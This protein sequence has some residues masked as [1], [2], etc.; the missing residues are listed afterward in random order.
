MDAARLFVACRHR[1]APC[2][3]RNEVARSLAVRL[4][5][6]V[7]E[8][9]AD[10]R[11]VADEKRY[12]AVAFK[13]SAKLLKLDRPVLRQTPGNTVIYIKKRI[14]DLISACVHH[15]ADK[16]TGGDA[17]PRHSLKRRHSDAVLFK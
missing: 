14:V 10:L 8:F 1:N 12:S 13:L 3:L 9:C 4:S 11:T 16:P 2:A 17:V 7:K 6:S 5:R 15:R